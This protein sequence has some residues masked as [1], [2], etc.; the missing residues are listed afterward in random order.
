MG[1][2]LV[3]DTL[4]SFSLYLPFANEDYMALMMLARGHFP[5][6][7][8]AIRQNSP[9]P[10][11]G[12]RNM[13]KARVNHPRIG[14]RPRFNDFNPRPHRGKQRDDHIFMSSH[15]ALQDGRGCRS[16]I[17]LG[18]QIFIKETPLQSLPLVAW[19]EEG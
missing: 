8:S 9:Q 7:V 17:K 18:F 4:L 3:L 15:R 12:A 2:L 16:F 6:A 1:N 10:A 13:H 14:G 5:E 11:S 19:L